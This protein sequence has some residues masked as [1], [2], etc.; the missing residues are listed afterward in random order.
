MP[1]HARKP[2]SQPRPLR[3]LAAQDGMTLVEVVVAAFM[4]GLIAMSLVGLSAAGRT[5]EDQ[6]MRSQA[7]ALAQQDQERMRAMTA[8]QLAKLNQTRQVTLE[9]KAFT[10]TS[11]ATYI[12]Q[13]AGAASCSGA[14]ADYAKVISTVD[15]TGNRR[16]AIVE[17]SV[18][19]PPAGGSFVVKTVDQNGA[20]LPGVT[21]TVQGTD[22][23]TDSTRR[24]A[25]TDSDGCAVFSGLTVGDYDVTAT[26]SGY[27]DA[28]GSSTP[29]TSATATAGNT[30]ETQFTMGVPGAVTARFS[31]TFGGT[32][33][34]DQLAPSISWFNTGMSTFGV[35][36]V[37]SPASSVATT[38]TLFPFI[39]G[40]PGQ[41]DGNYTLWAGRC[42]SNQPPPAPNPDVRPADHRGVAT[43]APGASAGS[44][45]V[46]VGLPTMIVNV[47]FRTSTS[48]PYNNVKPQGVRLDYTSDSG[49]SCGQSWN[50]PLNTASGP[51]PPTTGWLR[52]PGQPYGPNYNVCAY[53][54]HS[55]ENYRSTSAMSNTSYASTGNTILMSITGNGSSQG[56]C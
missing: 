2:K 15:W 22:G 53:Y 44:N 21:A 1:D 9:G 29:T 26:R 13:S 16:G 51:N 19:T 46:N 24:V 41:H 56:S 34:T 5:A 36:T 12:N 17:Q 48:Q 6:R 39:T 28:N 18:I 50:P 32:T 43:V 7:A 45:F 31:T 20:A 10:I 55:G 25:T 14:G 37:G 38:A 3:R 40:G 33:F 47:R 4:V 27:V 30:S 8:D 35:R 52:F 49:S 54:R 23:A 11:Q 42:T